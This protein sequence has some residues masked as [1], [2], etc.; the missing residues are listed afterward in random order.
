MSG[1][2]IARLGEERKAWR[3]DHPFVSIHFASS[4]SLQKNEKNRILHFF[5]RIFQ[6]FVARPTKNPDGTLNLM[7][8]DCAIP[9]KKSV[10]IFSTLLLLCFTRSIILCENRI[11]AFARVKCVAP[12]FKILE[13]LCVCVSY[14]VYVASYSH[15]CECSPHF[16]YV[17]LTWRHS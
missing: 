11:V 4:N 13:R 1:I 6:G 2:A 15:Q 10:W 8:W 3:K 14:I 7:L 9:G 17:R 5:N 16:L 12:Y